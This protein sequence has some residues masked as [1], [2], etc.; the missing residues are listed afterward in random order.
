M[1]AIWPSEKNFNIQP[2]MKGILHYWKTGLMACAILLLSVAPES[3]FEHIPSFPNED[4]LVHFLMYF[5]LAL[6]LLFDHVWYYGKDTLKKKATIAI[7]IG[8]PA[9][10]GGSMELAQLFFTSSR[11]A[12]IKDELCNTAGAIAGY[13]LGRY[14]MIIYYKHKSK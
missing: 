11:S 1:P 10:W 14:L 5:I 8:I 3:D 9:L 7:S 13:L 12:D 2:Y 4:K 6:L